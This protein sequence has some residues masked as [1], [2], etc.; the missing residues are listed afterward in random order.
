MPVR[1]RGAGLT[2]RFIAAT[3]IALGLAAA[4]I[5]LFMRHAELRQHERSAAE[6]ARFVADSILAG[7]LS[8]ADFADDVPAPRLAAIDRLVRTQVLQGGGLRAELYR[9]DGMIIYSTDGRLIGVPAPY[10]ERVDA[11][12]AGTTGAVRGTMSTARPKTPPV[13][14]LETY[15]PIRVDGRVIGVLGLAREYAPIGRAARAVY[16]PV[17]ATLLGALLLL[18]LV[19]V[20]SFRRVAKRLQ[21]QM[22]EVERQAL[23]DHLTGLPNRA[24]CEAIVAETLAGMGAEE[25]PFSLMIIDLDKFKEIN[26]TL[27]HPTGD[28]LLQELA[29]RLGRALEERALVARLGGDEFAILSLEAHDEEAAIALAEEVAAVT[30]APFSVGELE[31]QVEPS[32]GIAIF[33]EH[34]RDFAELTRHA[35][36]AMY[37]SK[38]AR[39]PVVYTHEV[40]HYTSDRLLLIGQLRHAF[41][42]RELVL[43]YQPQLD[44]RDREVLGVEA[45]V[46]WQHPDRGLLGP[47][48]FLGLARDAGL[49][50]QLTREVLRM[51]L[52]QSRRWRSTGLDLTI[53]VNVTEFEVL[54][55]SF[56]EYVAAALDRYGNDPSS[57]ELEITESSLLREPGRAVD[58]LGRLS[59][60]GV[61][62]A[63]DD[64]GVGYSSL[65]K[66]GRLPV[67]VLKIDRSF[68]TDMTTDAGAAAIVK[69]VVD[70]GH[71][72]GLRIVAEGVESEP[73]LEPLANHACDAVQGFHL[74]PPLS[75]QKLTLWLAELARPRAA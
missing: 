60:I 45:L 30:R 3:A 59:S 4:A 35:D 25:R 70:L 9:P 14:V 12:L 8:R 47:G 57:L 24:A 36:I 68:V 74:Q 38:E 41:E 71:N 56:P 72:L 66:L 55:A 43:H 6:Q 28:V 64:F 1:S 42:A 32:V 75:P 63:I 18:Y 10:P 44:L 20:P 61:R 29:W 2:W 7:G 27:G 65:S 17:S 49:L 39:A 11:A 19:L 13:D 58:V 52:A 67:D 62:V 40:D 15:A 34:G 46:R 22:L 33:P 48:E 16:L 37:A 31:L 26:D 50:S 54:D 23:H 51:A 53:A 69:S 21:G 73:L 5:L